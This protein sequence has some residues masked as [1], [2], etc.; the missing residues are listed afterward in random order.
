VFFNIF[1]AENL[2][3]MFAVLMEPY[4]IIHMSILLSVI[5]LWIE[6]WLWISSL[7][8]SVCF[9]GNPGSHSWNTGL[10]TLV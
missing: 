8:I 9:S 3:Q 2:P 6:L 1:A 4:A 7:A 10:K 5:K